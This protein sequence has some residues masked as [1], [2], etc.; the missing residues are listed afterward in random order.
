MF[1]VTWRKCLVLGAKICT[2]SLT[3]HKPC[4]ILKH[5]KSLPMASSKDLFL[6]HFKW[7]SVWTM[8]E[9]LK[10]PRPIPNIVT[11]ATFSHRKPKKPSHRNLIE[12]DCLPPRAPVK[13]APPISRVFKHTGRNSVGALQVSFRDSGSG[14]LWKERLMS[15]VVVLKF[16]KFWWCNISIG[17]PLEIPRTFCSWTSSWILFLLLLNLNA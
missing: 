8:G 6:A 9:T 15:F 13:S 14:I 3:S 12:E 4:A 7:K 10:S 16:A 1:L 17:L 2:S 5:D 11:E